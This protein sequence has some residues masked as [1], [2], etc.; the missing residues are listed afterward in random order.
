MFGQDITPNEHALARQFGVIDNFYDSG[1]VSGDGH[2]WSTAA[3]TTEYTELIWPIDYRGQEREYD[4]EG[5]VGDIYPIEHDEDDINEPGTGYI[6]TNA[7]RHHLS[8]P[9]LR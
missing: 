7:A 9:S 3:I 2:V 8:L 4:F 6:W 1:E 5:K